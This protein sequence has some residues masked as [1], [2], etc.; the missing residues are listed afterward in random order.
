M[1]RDYRD[2]ATLLWVLSQ[3]DDPAE[4]E[5]TKEGLI[6]LPVSVAK[7]AVQ[8]RKQLRPKPGAIPV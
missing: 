6:T 7:T 3:F 5:R 2:I 4:Y 8:S 1:L